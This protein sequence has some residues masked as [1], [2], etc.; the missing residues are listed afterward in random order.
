[1]FVILGSL[2][3]TGCSIDVRGDE[4]VVR[5]ERRFP[6]Q[7]ELDLALTTFDGSLEVQSW[8]RPE[9]LVEIERRASTGAAAE[10]L[11]VQTRAEGN[12]LIVEAPAPRGSDERTLTLGARQ[13]PSVR[14]RVTVPQQRVTLDARTG[15]GAVAARDLSGSVSLRSNDGAV[16]TDRIAGTLLVDTADGAVVVRDLRGS[17]DL[18]TGDGAVDVSGTL[19][20]VRIDTGDG[21][22]RIDAHAGSVVTSD[23]SVQSG[24]GAIALR[25]PREVDADVDAYSGDGRITISDVATASRSND[26]DR[27]AQVRTSLGRGGRVISLRTSDGSIS[28]TR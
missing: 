8:S 9:V 11:V 28:V 4:I 1:M 26:D 18:H 3:A 22:V 10:A 20:G 16:R 21:A 2:A 25:M 5:E 19:E 7:G 12:R 23:W 14:L 24:D 6:V 15:D 27:P 17:L 13:T